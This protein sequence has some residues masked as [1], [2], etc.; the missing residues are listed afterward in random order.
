MLA[1]GAYALTAVT[2]PSHPVP[3]LVGSSVADARLL[4]SKSKLD[5]RIQQAR[6][7]EGVPKDQI[8][9]QDPLPGKK[10][11]EG[12]DVAVVVSRG[13]EP[14]AVPD[15]AGKNQATAKALL[16]QAGFAPAFELRDSEEVAKDIVLDWAPK[17]GKQAKGT[18]VKVIV[19]NG[20][21]PR[22]VPDL[23]G[24]TFE[25]AAALLTP[26]RLTA[27]RADVFSDTVPVGQVVSSSPTAGG[28]AARDSKVTVNVSKGP[29]LIPIP[30]VR[31]K[32][33]IEAS[34]I[35]SA[36]GF[37]PVCCQGPANK[38]VTNTSPAPGTPRPKGAQV[39]LY[40]K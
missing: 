31:G 11:K 5:L 27:V 3:G 35:L 19:S 34:N 15:L 32:N 1:G 23:K 36:A 14:R 37:N 17:E 13:A 21:P 16:E 4:L 25:Q 12:E 10:L 7:D 24:K 38:P 6:F 29:E 8:L 18:A 28:K 20:P 33:V 39:G 26:L 22:T 2:K 30:D 40:T 9:R